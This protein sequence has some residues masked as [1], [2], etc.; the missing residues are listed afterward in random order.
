ME[1]LIVSTSYA[2]DY[3][4]ESETAFISQNLSEIM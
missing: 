3:R 2:V 1:H 4:D